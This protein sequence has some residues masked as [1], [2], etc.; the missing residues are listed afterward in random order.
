MNNLLKRDFLNYGG[1]F[2]FYFFTWAI[3]FAFLPIWLKDNA[4]LDE[5]QSGLV[6]SGIS[7][8]A[9]C[10]HPF[11]GYIQ[12]KLGY[13]K[14]LFAI[15]AGA[16]VFFGVFFN[17]LFI[18]LLEYNFWVA[19]FICS[20]YMSL[21]LY[22]GVGVVESY[23]ERVSRSNG[24]EYGHVRLFGSIAGA[25]ASFVGGILFLQ[26]P[27]NIFWAA[28]ISGAL[29]CLLLYLA[30]VKEPLKA[31][32][33]AASAPAITKKDVFKI[34]K[35]KDFW[36]F[37]LIIV[38]TAAI[39]DVFDQ[40]FPNYYVTFFQTKEAG[41]DTF[42]K[43]CAAQTAIEAVLMIFAP[44][45]VNKIGAKKGLLLFGV[46]TFVRIAGSAVF[47]STI[48]LSIFRLIAALEMPLMLV[49]VMKYITQVFDVRLS[50]SVYLLGF[51][52]AKQL[53]IVLFSSI[54]GGMYVN[55]GFQDTYIMLGTMVLIITFIS[56]FTLKN[57][58]N[59]PNLKLKL[60][61]N[62]NS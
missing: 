7:L 31:Q 38:G 56:I 26:N 23:I 12:D 62:K 47:T 2:Y 44:A 30:P 1:M 21:C 19:L 10:Y 39:Y 50:A 42:S 37:A 25:T 46:L 35:L 4:H 33:A 58:A 54:A 32:T 14:N 57:S 11:F 17:W 16:M 60:A 34:L 49:S 13:K 22:G 59:E 9:L 45:F 18:P 53:A 55:Y 36:A 52:L 40:Q 6:F 51:N 8:A 20:F 24:F 28:S 15:I 29:L 41:I 48:M 5:V 27:E 61:A 3:T 43:L